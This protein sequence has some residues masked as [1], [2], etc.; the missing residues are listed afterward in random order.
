M[1]NEVLSAEEIASRCEHLQ[2]QASIA[3]INRLFRAQDDSHKF[4]VRGRFDATERAIRK[5]RRQRCEG[6]ILDDGL[7]YATALEHEIQEVVNTQM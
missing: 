7:E 2:G 5:L 4:P 6:V 3:G 1:S